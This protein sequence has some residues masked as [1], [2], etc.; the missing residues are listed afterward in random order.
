MKYHYIGGGTSPRAPGPG[1]PGPPTADV[2]A[3]G[4]VHARAGD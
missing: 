1:F 2:R 3:P 4:D